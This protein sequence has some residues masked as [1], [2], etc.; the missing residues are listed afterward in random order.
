MVLSLM[1]CKMAISRQLS[2]FL[3]GVRFI[4]VL[5]QAKSGMLCPCQPPDHHFLS[6]AKRI[7]PCQTWFSVGSFSSN[8]PGQ[9]CSQDSRDINRTWSAYSNVPDYMPD[10]DFDLL[11]QS[12]KNI[13]IDFLEKGSGRKRK[14]CESNTLI[15]RLLHAPIP[16]TSHHLG[17]K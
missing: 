9:A 17:L 13:F 1:L 7:S 15:R 16:P 10:G 2:V 6:V 5:L 8:E 11:K 14:T 12:F 3:P 4:S